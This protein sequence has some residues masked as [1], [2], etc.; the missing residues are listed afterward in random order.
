M[1][2]AISLHH[3]TAMEV[4]PPEL[5]S[6]AAE[7]GLRHVCLFTCITPETLS[8][9]PVEWTPAL[10]KE[11]AA[12]CADLDVTVHNLEWFDVTP[13]ADEDFHRAGLELGA[14]FGARTATTHVVDTDLARAADNF[15]RFC[16]LA[17]EYGITPCIE[18]TVMIGTP[19][20]ASAVKVIDLSGHANGGVALDALHL[21]RSG[22]TVDDVRALD[23]RYVRSVQI[24][25]GPS[26]RDPADYFDEAVFERMIPGEGEFPL[27]ALLSVIP[28]DIILDVEVPLRTRRQAGLNALDRSRLAVAGLRSM[29]QEP[30]R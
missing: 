25:D 16:E 14:S 28:A 8:L 3:V 15:A 1:T 30:V 22:G 26:Q 9:F 11:T 24:S 27:Q 7:L 18:F 6:I 23:P 10:R 5:V 13:D 17:G 19:T 12:R 4:S 21:F 29:V 20:L 2:H